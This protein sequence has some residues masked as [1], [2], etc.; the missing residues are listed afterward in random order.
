LAKIRA[1]LA[2]MAPLK[3]LTFAHLL[4]PAIGMGLMKGVCAGLRQVK[5]LVGA[6]DEERRGEGLEL[7]VMAFCRLIS[8]INKSRHRSPGSL[9]AGWVYGHE[10]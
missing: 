8:R 2:S 6:L 7:R 5:S 1:R 3:C 4:C 10:S 9:R